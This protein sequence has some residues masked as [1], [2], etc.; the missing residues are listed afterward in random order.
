VI[1]VVFGANAEGQYAAVLVCSMEGSSK[2]LR[3]EVGPSPLSATRAIVNGLVMDTGLLFGTCQQNSTEIDEYLYIVG[4]YDVGDQISDQQGHQNAETEA[5]ELDA[6]KSA[7]RDDWPVDA[8]ETLR[9]SNVMGR[10]FPPLGSR[11]DREKDF[12][13]KRL[14][15]E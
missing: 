9:R 10:A 4:K 8:T 14:R 13:R 7:L 12:V 1:D 5:F 11:A 15:Y 3:R 6:N 2:I